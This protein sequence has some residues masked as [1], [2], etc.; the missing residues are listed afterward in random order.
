MGALF[1]FNCA[2]C[3]IVEIGRS[4]TISGMCALPPKLDGKRCNFKIFFYWAHFNG[5]W[6]ICSFDPMTSPSGHSKSYEVKFVFFLLAF[7]KIEIERWKW[8]QSVAL[9]KTHLLIYN[10]TY[11]A[12]H[13]H[14][15]SRDLDLRSNYDIDLGQ[16]VGTYF[17]AFQKE[18]YDS[19]RIIP[20][21]FLVQK[22]FA[23]NRFY[24]KKRY[25]GLSWPL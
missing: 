16:H 20:L 1:P 22:L 13:Q 17:D 8:S 25:F 10:M 6:S 2:L 21:A 18:E 15:T 4:R 19:A 14:V 7:D 3:R 23:K 24:K 5:P 12:Q 9:A 11:L